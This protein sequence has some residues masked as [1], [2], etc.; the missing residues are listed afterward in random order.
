MPKAVGVMRHRLPHFLHL[1]TGDAYSAAYY[2]YLWAD[3]LTADAWEAFTEA[4]GPWDTEVAGR[5]R[6]NVFSA[7]NTLDA[8]EAYRAFR[9]RDPDTKALMRKRGFEDQGATAPE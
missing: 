1:F 4:D 9:G 7:G 2:S 5:L 6:K 8:A 3:V